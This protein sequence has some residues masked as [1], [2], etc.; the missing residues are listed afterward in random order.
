MLADVGPVPETA[1]TLE[2]SV[3]R[4]VSSAGVKVGLAIAAAIVG[5]AGRAPCGTGA[6]GAL[7]GGA[8]E[9]YIG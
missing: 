4:D 8:S 1:L 2:S 3:P 6:G 9:A 7:V 5:G